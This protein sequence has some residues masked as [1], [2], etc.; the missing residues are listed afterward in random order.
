MLLG[1]NLE[2]NN[3]TTSATR[4]QILKKLEY[5]AFANKHVPKETIGVQQ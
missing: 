2:I 1:K 5:A 4:Q 3:E